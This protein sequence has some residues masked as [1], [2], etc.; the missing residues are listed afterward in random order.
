MKTGPAILLLAVAVV[1]CRGSSAGEE[2][3]A[4]HTAP[5]SAPVAISTADV[6]KGQW[7][8][9]V[10]KGVVRCEGGSVI[11]RAADGT[12]YAVN[13][14]AKTQHP[15]LP[16]IKKIWKKDPIIPG[17]RTNIAPVLNRGLELCDG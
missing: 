9:T 7:P 1:G 15:D 13:R 5:Q 16:E 4:T 8:L 2:S 10:S 17:A 6:L 11:F 14:T 3:A 12:D